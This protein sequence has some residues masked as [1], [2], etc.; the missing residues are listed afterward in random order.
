MITRSTAAHVV[1]DAAGVSVVCRVRARLTALSRRGSQI[2][3]WLALVSIAGWNAPQVKSARK[4][5]GA[6]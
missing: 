4:L 6:G 3:E 2:S 1:F 5:D